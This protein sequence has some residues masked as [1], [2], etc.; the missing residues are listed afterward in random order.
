MIG[1]LILD[2]LI[3]QFEILNKKCLFGVFRLTINAMKRKLLYC[4]YQT[5]FDEAGSW[6]FPIN[7]QKMLVFSVENSSQDANVEK[8]FFKL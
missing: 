7:L 6:N 3:Y 8:T 5:A 1:Q 2:L 4:G